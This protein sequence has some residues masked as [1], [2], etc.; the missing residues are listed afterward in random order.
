MVD[1]ASDESQS[2]GG[3]S[4]VS[5]SSD[6]KDFSNPDVET[7][8][9]EARRGL[10][11][12]SDLSVAQLTKL[13]ADEDAVVRSHALG[14][15]SVT[16]QML[17]AILIQFPE[18]EKRIVR[19]FNASAVLLGRRPACLTDGVDRRKYVAGKSREA[20]VEASFYSE[21]SQLPPDDMTTTL[22]EVW[23]RVSEAEA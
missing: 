3:W 1:E 14:N 11:F 6:S 7:L 16:E 12:R 10:A 23:A 9:R 20:G 8:D 18:D 13:L 19:H 2:A 4:S 5:S 22:D 17:D 15:V 21:L